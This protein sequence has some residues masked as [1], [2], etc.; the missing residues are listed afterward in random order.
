MIGWEFVSEELLKTL[1]EEK[2]KVEELKLQLKS[3]LA[4]RSPPAQECEYRADVIGTPTMYMSS[5]PKTPTV[6]YSGAARGNNISPPMMKT[7]PMSRHQDVE[8]LVQERDE[9]AAC[10]QQQK[11]Q[12]QLLQTKLPCGHDTGLQH[13]EAPNVQHGNNVTLLDSTLMQSRVAA[14]ERQLLQAEEQALKKARQQEAREKIQQEQWNVLEGKLL[15]AEERIQKEGRERWEE[16]TRKKAQL[17]I[18][19]RRHNLELE[20]YHEKEVQY[21]SHVELLKQQLA[22]M[23]ITRTVERQTL[24]RSNT[25]FGTSVSEYKLQIDAMRQAASRSILL[26][27]VKS[28][29]WQKMDC[30]KTMEHEI[31]IRS[32]EEVPRFLFFISTSHDF[33]LLLFPAVCKCRGGDHD[34]QVGTSHEQGMQDS[35]TVPAL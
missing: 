29:V 23:E 8:K 14:L 18:L 20:A 10:C 5:P 17:S 11:E 13:R 24:E 7:M 33:C 19:L 26:H 22:E 28:T 4:C 34:S 9:L 6:H 31:T 30:A 15:H 1:G 12:I 27:E 16:D 25:E 2:L 3:A 21:K 35:G 32:L